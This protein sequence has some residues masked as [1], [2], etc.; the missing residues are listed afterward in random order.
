MDG[1]NLDDIYFDFDGPSPVTPWNTRIAHLLTKKYVSEP[2]VMVKDEVRV[3]KAFTQRLRKLH[4][5]Y[6]QS[7][8]SLSPDEVAAEELKTRYVNR[9]A[10]QYYVSCLIKFR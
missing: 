1:P 4:T 2:G 10:R 3:K 9:K 8:R 7:L 5:S 6:Q